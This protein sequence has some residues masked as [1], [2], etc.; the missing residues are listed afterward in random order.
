MLVPAASR[1]GAGAGKTDDDNLEADENDQMWLNRTLYEA[2]PFAYAGIGIVCVVGGFFIDEDSWSAV[3]VVFGLLAIVGGL[4]LFLKRRGY[5]SSRS[6]M[7][8]DQ[9]R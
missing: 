7:S 6:R 1:S 4:V 5:R 8:F 2:L 3:A 9:V